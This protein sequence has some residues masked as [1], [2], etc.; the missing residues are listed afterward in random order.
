MSKPAVNIYTYPISFYGTNEDSPTFIVVGENDKIVNKTVLK[1][2]V[3]NLNNLNI[4]A[5]YTEM[6]RLEHGFGIDPE[7]AGSIN[8]ISRAIAFWGKNKEEF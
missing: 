7:T 6:P 1:S 8:R 3:A 5:K 2:S 4:N